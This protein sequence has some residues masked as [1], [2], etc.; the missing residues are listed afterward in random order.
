M[1]DPYYHV[2]QLRQH[3]VGGPDG[4]HGYFADSVVDGR[5]VTQEVSAHQVLHDHVAPRTGW[6][7]FVRDPMMGAAKR[8]AIVGGTVA[9]GCVGAGMLLN[10]LS[11]GHER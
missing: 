8:T 9:L 6:Q 2:S 7:K 5:R 3:R 11:N 1:S 10:H 4:R